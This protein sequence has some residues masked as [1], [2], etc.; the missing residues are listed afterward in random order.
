MNN[1]KA[2]QIMK[3]MG[4]I[5]YGYVDKDNNKHKDIGNE[6]SNIYQLQSPSELIKSKLGVCWDQVELERYYFNKENIKCKTYFMVYYNN[7]SCPTHTFLVFFENDK[8]HWFEHSWERYRGIYEYETLEQLINDIR[9]KF[10]SDQLILPINID[11]LYIYEYEKPKYNISCSE[12]YNYCEK[13][14]ILNIK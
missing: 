5:I 10:I 9:E 1:I 7:T 3:L 14:I 11:N 2:N 6:F 4:D 13:G 8:Y 12:F